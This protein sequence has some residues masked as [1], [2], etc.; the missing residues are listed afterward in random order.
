MS[1]TPDSAAE[2]GVQTPAEDRVAQL[3]DQLQGLQ[4]Q[5]QELT[6]ILAQERRERRQGFEDLMDAY[7]L[8]TATGHDMAPP[9]RSPYQPLPLPLLTQME[10][11]DEIWHSSYP[12]ST[13]TATPSF[14][15]PSGP[16]QP[17][18]G[19]ATELGGYSLAGA[20]PMFIEGSSLGISRDIWA[21]YNPADYEDD[22]DEGN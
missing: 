22:E 16:I 5:I 14:V 3:F 11:T 7:R 13:L 2:P 12:T 21:N 17:S 20:R 8:T 18:T 1:N 10:L 6:G 9:Q 19:A 4:L 15:L